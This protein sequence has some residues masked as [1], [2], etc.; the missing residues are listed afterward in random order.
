MSNK[1]GT[2]HAAVMV[3]GPDGQL[4]DLAQRERLFPGQTFDSPQKER[5]QMV[6]TVPKPVNLSP[7]ETREIV[8]QQKENRC[9]YGGT[10]QSFAYSGNSGTVSKASGPPVFGSGWQQ[11]GFGSPDPKKQKIGEMTPYS[12]EELAEAMFDCQFYLHPCCHYTLK[13]MV[14][15]FALCSA[16]RCREALNYLVKYE[17]IY[18]GIGPKDHGHLAYNEQYWSLCPINKQ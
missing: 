9:R 10:G 13:N 1:T 14:D 15:E 16:F 11:P 3:K 5:E 4:M 18:T 17:F 8:R 7:E 2:F 6:F 12:V